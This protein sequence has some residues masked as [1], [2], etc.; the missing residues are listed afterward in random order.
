MAKDRAIRATDA[1][2]TERVT[3]IQR[4]L[5]NGYTRSYIIQFA[6]KKW[7]LAPRTVDDYIARATASIRE[8]NGVERED[9]L[10][11]IVTNQWDMF[12]AARDTGQIESARK[13]LMDIAKLRGLDEQTIQHFVNERPLADVKDEELDKVLG[14]GNGRH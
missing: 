5:L 13:I 6:E 10:A 12:R 11:T 7:K 9:N 3:E 14:E 2:M 1:T 8:I 4:Y